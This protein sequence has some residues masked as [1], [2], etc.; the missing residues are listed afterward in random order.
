MVRRILL[1][2]VATAAA[3]RAPARPR[4][5]STQPRGLLAKTAGLELDGVPIST[6]VEP[7]G[8]Y[9]FAKI[10]KPKEE[11]AS[12]LFISSKNQDGVP[13]GIVVSVS[14]GRRHFE[15]GVLIP[16]AVE[17]GERVLHAKTAG[18]AMRYCGEDHLMLRD[19]DIM[20][21]WAGEVM[22]LDA[23]RPVRDG[24]I[25][26]VAAVEDV[27]LSGIAIAAGAVAQQRTSSGQIVKVGPGRLAA[28][29][30]LMPMSVA[31]GDYVKFRDYAG[32]E[33][34]LDGEKYVLCRMADCLAKW[35]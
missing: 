27:T 19:D 12:G 16:V 23:V 17:A 26:K 18:V 34:K 11:T 22:S 35:H 7:V 14:P 6:P 5:A 9:L 3:L 1:G 10:V 28:T 13:E 30:E 32:V 15:T 21:A 25:V 33:I 31:V 29:G 24:I 4:A 8:S 20:L 2:L